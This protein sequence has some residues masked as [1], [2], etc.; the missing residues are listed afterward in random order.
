MNKHA[1][2]L[3]RS[4]WETLQ[5]QKFARAY[6]EAKTSVVTRTAALQVAKRAAAAMGLKAAKLALIDQLFASSKACDWTIPGKPPVVWPSNARLARLLGIGISTMKH[7]LNGLVRAG[8]VAYSDHPTYQRRGV[9]DDD[10]NIVEA[11]GI[12]LS[13]IAVRY[14]DLLELAETAE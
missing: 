9:R 6:Q 14:G 10:G 13:P 8:L 3:R 12:D 5:A 7:H 11:Y 1:A 4:S 2:G